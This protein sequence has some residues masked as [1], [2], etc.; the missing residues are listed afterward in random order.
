[1]SR[2]TGPKARHCRRLGLNIYGSEK[3]DKILAK[4][5]FAPGM[6]GN[7][8]FSQKSEYGKQLMEKQK[9]RLMYGVTER[10]FQTYYKKAEAGAGITGEELIRLLER[11]ID[12]VLFRA[13]FAITRMQARQM[14][15]HGLMMLNG[16]K[17]KTPSIQIK[18]GDKITVRTKSAGSPLFDKVKTGNEK[19]RAP[20][21]LTADNSK[22]SVEV[23]NL[24]EKDDLENSIE[25]NLIVEYYSK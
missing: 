9:A 18:V 10:Q 3:Y 11:R 20:K 19:F 5:N 15:S 4:R 14:V 22:L 7:K 24:P 8:M 16:K 6:H 2:Y 25:S 13:G 1:M 12:N 17:I 23:L 21:W